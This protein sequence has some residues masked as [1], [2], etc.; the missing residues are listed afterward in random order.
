MNK[1]LRLG[2]HT[3]PRNTVAAFAMAL[4]MPC[5]AQTIATVKRA[6]ANTSVEQAGAVKYI[7]GGVGLDARADVQHQ[8]QSYNLRMMFAE[9]SG[10]F[11]IPDSVSLRKGQTEVLNVGNAG[12]LLYV[13]VPNGTYT[14]HAS[15]RGVV[16]TKAVTVAGRTPDVVLTWPADTQ[17][18]Q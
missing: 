4:A 13:N 14:I 6:L 8:A 12:P 18:M 3:V 17:S 11:L 9:L 2:L 5:S 16:R 1:R 15:Y 10:A 7:S